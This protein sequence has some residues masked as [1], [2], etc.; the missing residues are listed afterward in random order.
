MVWQEKD[1]PPAPH[2]APCCRQA[3]KI[4]IKVIGEKPGTKMLLVLG[5]RYRMFFLNSFYR[6]SDLNI[7]LN[8]ND[9][10]RACIYSNGLSRPVKNGRSVPWFLG[11][12]MCGTGFAF[13]K[14]IFENIL[15]L[16]GDES[17]FFADSANTYQYLPYELLKLDLCANAVFGRM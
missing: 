10:D 16:T 17:V 13:F 1:G 15:S 7:D 12:S 14:N 6:Y 8:Q 11:Y 9:T 5:K 2:C 4:N 3:F